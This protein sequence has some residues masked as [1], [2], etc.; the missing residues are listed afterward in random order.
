MSED[1][2][3][4]AALNLDSLFRPV[5]KIEDLCKFYDMSEDG[6]IYATLNID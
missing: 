1:G 2:Y 5:W 4:H 3:I 6:Y